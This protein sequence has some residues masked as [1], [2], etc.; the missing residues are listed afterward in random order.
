MM[1]EPISS[2]GERLSRT[3]VLYNKLREKCDCLVPRPHTCAHVRSSHPGSAKLDERPQTHTDPTSFGDGVSS[4]LPLFVP[5]GWPLFRR[6]RAKFLSLFR[7]E[8]GEISR[9][10][11]EISRKRNFLRA[12][13]RT[14]PFGAQ[15][16]RKFSLKFR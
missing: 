8:R 11:R 15:V 6:E 16:V 12:H 3:S 4:C 10:F 13:M 1:A 7:W 2:N 5:C 14:V 9:K